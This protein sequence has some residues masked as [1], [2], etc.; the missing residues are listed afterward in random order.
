MDTQS[1]KNNA[2]V[3]EPMEPIEP[4][5]PRGNWFDKEGKDSYQEKQ[6][7]STTEES[8]ELFDIISQYKSMLVEAKDIWAHILL[9]DH[10]ILSSVYYPI[11]MSFLRN[12]AEST[13]EVEAFHFSLFP[14]GQ[15][16]GRGLEVIIKQKMY[17]KVFVVLA[18]V[19]CRRFKEF[20]LQYSDPKF[21]SKIQMQIDIA[22]ECIRV[23]MIEHGDV[24]NS[25]FTAILH[26]KI[27]AEMYI[28][29]TDSRINFKPI[30]TILRSTTTFPSK[31]TRTMIFGGGHNANTDLC[32]VDKVTKRKRKEDNKTDHP[33]CCFIDE[34]KQKG[35]LKRSSA[36]ML[37]A[38]K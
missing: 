33:G 5:E 30:L 2:L 8:D 20:I 38:S 35:T 13:C 4:M 9:A 37:K 36:Y 24:T 10:D 26:L 14:S 32:I 23:A 19:T 1:I 27:M 25:M 21:R 7:E 11:A 29:S 22:E 6:Q 16:T 17:M 15:L 3:S 34:H 18:V 28:H 31:G 12:E